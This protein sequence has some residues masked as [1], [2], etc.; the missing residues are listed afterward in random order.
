MT[1]RIRHRSPFLL[2]AALLMLPALSLFAAAQ[3]GDTEAAPK[4][5]LMDPVAPV[6]VWSIIVFLVVLTILW[7]T[8][9]GPLLRA[10]DQR[11][12][13]IR[14]SL[15]AAQRAREEGARLA[16]DHEKLMARARKEATDIVEEGK[17][18]AHVVKDGI[19][20]DARK[21]AQD[22]ANRAKAEITRAKDNAVHEIHERAVDLSITIA[23]KLIRRSLSSE[24]HEDLVKDA[25]DR[26]D[27]RN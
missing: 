13:R 19:V 6:F 24:D 15:E 26:Y 5:G 8:A 9:W 14:E 7:K 16:A 17:R 23:E 2:G 18:D 10:L 27:E 20:A 12:A 22:I 1:G 21:E 25:I 3:H 4:P 11:V